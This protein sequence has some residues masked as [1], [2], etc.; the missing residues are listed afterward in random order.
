MPEMDG[1]EVCRQINQQRLTLQIPVMFL[2]GAE[3]VEIESRC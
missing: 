3:S 1:I 2:T